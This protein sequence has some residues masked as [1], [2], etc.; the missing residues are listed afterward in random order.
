MQTYVYTFF[1]F[2]KI[3]YEFKTQ[4]LSLDVTYVL[5]MKHKNNTHI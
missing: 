5:K 3:I 4:I 1:S 2:K